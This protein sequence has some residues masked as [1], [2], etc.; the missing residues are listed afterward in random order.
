MNFDDD[1][2]IGQILTRREVLGLLGAG[3]ALAFVTPCLPLLNAASETGDAASCV[4]RPEMTEGPYFVDER[5]NRS[6]IRTDPSDGSVK[7]GTPL[8][9]TFRISKIVSGACA[10][11]AGAYVDVWHC[12]ALGIYSDVSDPGFNTTGKKFLRGYQ[13]SN[14]NG[15]ARF[16]TIY[17]GWYGGRTVHIHFKVRTALSQPAQEFISQLFFDDSLTD[18]VHS[19]GPYSSKGKRRVRNSDDWIYR[20]GGNQLLLAPVQ[21]QNGYSAEISLAMHLNA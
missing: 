17:P 20:S 14:G 9:L 19:Q 3:A 21:N 13:V 11:L 7:K 12:D 5:L 2:P 18:R 4:V 8:A 6:D 16:M 15:E 10:P 1:R